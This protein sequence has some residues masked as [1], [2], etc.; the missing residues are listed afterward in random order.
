ME[1]KKIITKE[2]EQKYQEQGLV[3][4]QTHPT[5]DL[6]IIN[7]SEKVT[8]ENLW[9]ENLLKYRA[10][11]YNSDYEVVAKSF[12]RFFNMEEE[13]HE[14]TDSFEVFEKLDGSLILVFWYA[15]QM[16]VASRGSFT[17]PYALEAKMLL[18]TKYSAFTA[19]ASMFQ[20]AYQ[21]TYCFELIGFEQIVV[22][23]AQSDIVLTGLFFYSD[24]HG[25]WEEEE[26]N[27][28]DDNKTGYPSIVK[29][30]DGLDWKNIKGLNWQNAEGFVVRFSN[31]QRCKIKFEDY[32]KL[33]RQMTNLTTR[34]IWKALAD[35]EPVSSILN[36]VP[37]EFYDKVHDYE[38]LLKKN[39]SD[40]ETDIKTRY[41]LEYLS[42]LKLPDYSRRSTFAS[43]V[44]KY[45]HK[46]ALFAML[47]G[48]DY[49]GYIWKQ[50]EPKFEKL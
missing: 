42:A 5:L 15:G 41:V 21:F 9:D 46:S 35:G 22:H 2:L 49:S 12:D 26:I 8:Y 47:D 10:L 32:I 31:G 40:L 25:M 1:A 3:R 38:K 43:N 29:K 34:S 23:Y 4:I 37:D 44:A 14:A 36:D 19:I 7:Y 28:D 16:I 39:Y 50:V 30:F 48:K 33:H 24:K 13:K 45:P 17:S 11:V 18:E 6:K 27:Y 20:D